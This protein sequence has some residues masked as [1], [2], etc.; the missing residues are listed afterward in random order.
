MRKIHSDIVKHW[1]IS[2]LSFYVVCFITFVFFVFHF[3][4]VY[5]FPFMHI[6]IANEQKFCNF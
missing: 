4:V 1:Y 6:M 2:Q 3:N 5:I